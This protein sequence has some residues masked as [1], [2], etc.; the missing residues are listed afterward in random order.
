MIEK[1]HL[2]RQR[3]NKIVKI[4]YDNQKSTGEMHKI[5]KYQFKLC[6][7]KSFTENCPQNINSTIS[8]KMIAK[9]F[10]R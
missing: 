7:H 9:I 2:S 10:Y 3:S 4:D 5:N 6:I 1:R 8:M